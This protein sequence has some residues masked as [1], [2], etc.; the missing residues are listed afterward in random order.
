MNEE[1]HIG[2][3]VGR[4]ASAFGGTSKDGGGPLRKSEPLNPTPL[5]KSNA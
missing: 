4:F 1:R 3:C 2:M 5:F